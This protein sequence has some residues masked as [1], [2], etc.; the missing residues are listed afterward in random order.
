MN[1]K[2]K[3]DLINNLSQTEFISLKEED[4]S[5]YNNI[6]ILQE[7]L[8]TIQNLKN[9]LNIIEKKEE[10]TIEE[11]E[12]EIKET[13][14]NERKSSS[15]SSEDNSSIAKDIPKIYLKNPIDFVNYL[16][17]ELPNKRMNKVNNK[18]II[19]R[20]EESNHIKFNIMNINIDKELNKVI[21][22]K[23]EIITSIYYYE[24]DFL[25][26]GNILGQV[27]IYSLNDKKLLKTLENPPQNKNK[28]NKV[29]TMDLS[30]DNKNI[31]IGYSNGNISIA[32]M[33]TQKIKLVIS[34]IINNS[35]CLCIKFIY[36]EKKFY[37][38]IASD[39][40]GNIYLIKIKDGLTG[41]RVVENKQILIENNKGNNPIY[42]IK[43]LDFNEN[44][45][46]RYT[47]L[48]SIKKYLIF[49]NLNDI[50]IYLYENDD[51]FTLK[52]KIEKPEWIKEY[53]IN[54]ICFGVGENPQNRHLMD[55]DEDFPQILMGASFN[56]IINLYIITVENG[57][58]NYPVLIGH[59]LN[60]NDNGNNQIIRIGFL[61]KGCIFLID[62][63]NNLKILSTKKFIKGYPKMNEETSTPII[64]KEIKYNLAEIQEI[65][66]FKSGINYQINII[67]PRGN[68]KQNYI[69]SIVQNFI[70][71][72]IVILSDKNL[73]L[74]NFVNYDDYLKELQKKEKWMEMFI[75]GI[76][77]YKG[78]IT[79]LKGIPQNTEERKKK[80]K[81]YLEQLILVYIIADDLNQ[82]NKDANNNSRRN[83]FYGNRDFLK[84]IGNKIEMIIEFCIEIE[85]F[86]FLLDKILS[87]Y[88]NKEFLNLFLTKLESFILCNKMLKYEIKEDIILKL[89]QLYVNENKNN[90][91]NKILLHINAKSLNSP[92][93]LNKI[94]ELNLIYPLMNI[95]VNGENPDYLKPIL[96]LY[97]LYKKGKKLNFNTYE[98]IIEEK[99]IEEIKES[100]EYIGHKIFW[101]I[102]KCFIKR[103]YPYFIDNMK[104]KEYNKYI[105][106][107]I[108]WLMEENV[109]KD[110]IEI[111]SEFYF[112]I[113]KQIFYNENNLNII[114]NY[115]LDK[116][117]VDKTI[118]TL[119]IKNY[120]YT[121]KDLLPL[122]LLNYIIEQ[123]KK[124]EGDQN[125]KL[126]FN[127]FII[128]CY[129]NIKI[130]KEII[131]G[132]IIFILSVYNIINKE[133]D[134]K[135]KKVINTIINALNYDDIFTLTDYENILIHFSG[136]IFD[137]IK[138][139]IYEKIKKY[140]NCLEIFINKESLIFDKED[141][142]YKYV[143]KIFTSLS[144]QNGKL[145][146]EFKNFVSENIANI[147]EIS[148]QKMLEIIYKWFYTNYE[149]KKIIMEKLAK[150]PEIQLRY[151]EPLYKEFIFDYKE[152]NS[153]II[154][155]NQEL[156]ESIMSLYIKLLC[157]TGKK[158]KVLPCLKECSLF[159][160][161]KCKD[162][163]INY[164][165]KDSLIYLYIISGDFQNALKFNFKEIDNIFNSL[166]NNLKSDI[167]KNNEFSEQI[168]E[169]NESIN[170]GLIIITDIQENKRE[171][172]KNLSGSDKEW[173]SIL[174][175][176]YD[177]SIKFN[178]EID[179]ISL[180][181]K[182]YIDEFDKIISDTIILILDKMS[183]YVSIKRI[184]EEV[185]KN[186]IAGYKEFR[187]LFIKIF[188]TY[189]IQNSILIY[190]VKLLKNL[191][192]ENIKEYKEINNVGNNFELN[193][194]SVCKENFEKINKYKI[195]KILIF[196]CGHKMHFNCSLTEK[197]GFKEVLICP[198]CKK[199][200]IELDVFH[201]MNRDELELMETKNEEIIKDQKLNKDGIDIK[202]YKIG[203]N[204]MNDINNNL[205]H[206]NKMFFNDCIK[207]V[208]RIN[209]QKIRKNK[210]KKTKK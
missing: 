51:E 40:I 207:V 32:D 150:K 76:N 57:E 23:D 176:L 206:K 172:E 72:N 36:N 110:L 26:V 190:A 108:L 126:C 161:E 164:D 198:I 165:V 135:T 195:R 157:I 202:N 65:Y 89:I 149:D 68:F 20:Y 38:I 73:Y 56:D 81:E 140:K 78:N 2:M 208:E 138:I 48:K 205:M 31:F 156:V 14:K 80:L 95:Y 178:Q 99:N 122:N 124:I 175:K 173:F 137:E 62:K 158:E 49:G 168:S 102:Q 3:E 182:K 116:G 22:P 45:T 210:S 142:L 39:Q 12:E 163:C 69:N 121:Y 47:F 132:S 189:D 13:I 43:F 21:F 197:E 46:K 159:P 33:K 25:I 180:N 192:F 91:L 143:D 185:S 128:Q 66:K 119:N 30:N 170:K 123:V 74:L 79:S 17:C 87:I 54:D 11:A 59:Y 115:N 5:K 34:D 209:Y 129:K 114:K 86:D 105:I 83:S 184:L 60:I 94:K 200:E 61:A 77:I 96:L 104:E 133:M 166:I 55:Y 181:R 42:Y 44:I 84:H 148:E 125:M 186:K 113:L 151:I 141:K 139:F 144:E 106:D 10:P 93:I 162:I 194:C 19:K 9:D 70:T 179:N 152:N 174:N 67:T 50:E 18:F 155:E 134:N 63:D 111:N 4:I 167:F 71:N 120:K 82:K 75:L 7:S 64:D 58:I 100:K 199:Y 15:S 103:K 90:V 88:E 153:K 169:F 187:P 24:Q 85:V 131:I 109:M 171:E 98:K 127:I 160:I 27:K 130:P 29:T 146:L 112:D 6:D 8:N 53:T 145:F 101:Y 52:Y 204:R 203:F 41:C 196:K 191:C 183:S 147:G 97:D 107:L 16:E 201:L 1:D 92:I 35:E 37:K 136:H 118:K 28:N 117:S 188:E 154:N 193:K 177:I